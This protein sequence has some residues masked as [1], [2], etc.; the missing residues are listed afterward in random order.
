MVDLLK[1]KDNSS[2]D[3]VNN[4]VG[5]GNAMMVLRAIIG[6]EIKDNAKDNRMPPILAFSLMMTTVWI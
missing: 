2:K 6:E 5:I 4:G 1:V 3:K